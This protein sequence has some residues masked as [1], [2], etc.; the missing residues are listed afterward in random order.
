MTT[1]VQFS[2]VTLHRDDLGGQSIDLSGRQPK[3][4]KALF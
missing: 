1:S 2:Y 4:A 3:K